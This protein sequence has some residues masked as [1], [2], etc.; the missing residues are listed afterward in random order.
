[1]TESAPGRTGSP[2]EQT[3]LYPGCTR[4]PAPAD[5][6][7]RPP[8]Y[9]LQADAPGGVVHDK[10]SAF[11]A[12]RTATQPGPPAHQASSSGSPDP[13]PAAPVTRAAARAEELLHRARTLAGELRTAMD[14]VVGALAQ[15]A[16][17]QAA[18]EEI[19]ATVG[20]AQQQRAAAEARAARAEVARRRADVEAEEAV[21]AAEEALTAEQTAR[22][23]EAAALDTRDR[24]LADATTATSRAQAAETARDTLRTHLH[25]TRD[26]ARAE[27]AAARS[28]AAE[29]AAQLTGRIDTL[30]SAVT[31]ARDDATTARRDADQARHD[32][33]EQARTAATATG[34]AEAAQARAAQA[35]LA[36]ADR[37]AERDALRDRLRDA[38]EAL[39]TVR[40]AAA[41]VDATAAARQVSD[42]RRID[43]LTAD[44]AAARR[45]VDR[46]HTE[47]RA[48]AVAAAGVAAAGVGTGEDVS[49][50]RT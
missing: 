13:G 21:A 24:A 35:E 16:D 42:T 25:E 26:A 41:V 22:A 30:T 11:R 23:A 47:L 49:V 36:L 34:R 20:A 40:Q 6:P 44:L 46:L 29:R 9:C 45:D 10:A 2:I 19:A 31:T 8:A 18:Q 50:P 37:T 33:V 15:V 17:P 14:G 27:I 1:M 3:C 43:D 7:G 5:G 48:A 38:V 12:R 28:A 4:P 39:A 32:L